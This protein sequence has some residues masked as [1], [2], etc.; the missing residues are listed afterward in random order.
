M[1]HLMVMIQSF[2]EDWVASKDLR[3]PL[4]PDLNSPHLFLWSYLKEQ[5]FHNNPCTTQ[6]LKRKHHKWNP[7]TW[8]HH[9]KTHYQQHA[10][11]H[12]EVPGGRRRSCLAC[13]VNFSSMNQRAC[14][15]N[16]KHSVYPF[17]IYNY[18][19]GFHSIQITLQYIKVPQYFKVSVNEV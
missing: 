10:T 17:I 16:I 12:P 1:P 14:P 2:F 4:S 6:A 15:Y 9:T 7:V 5:L 13:D 8:Q 11:L 19:F 3:P 18:I